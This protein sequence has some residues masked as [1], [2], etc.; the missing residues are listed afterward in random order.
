VKVDPEQEAFR[1]LHV[2]DV[3]YA[4]VDGVEVHV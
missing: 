2:G 4:I 3:L 1:K